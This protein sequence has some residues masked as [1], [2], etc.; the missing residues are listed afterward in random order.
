MLASHRPL[1]PRFDLAQLS[2]SPLAHHHP[3]GRSS[4]DRDRDDH[5][6]SSSNTRARAGS[7][8][9]GAGAAP[10]GGWKKELALRRFGRRRRHQRDLRFADRKPCQLYG[11]EPSEYLR[12]LLCLLPSWNVQRVLEMSPLRWRETTGREDVRA[13]LASNVYR[14]V[15]LGELEPGRGTSS[16]TQSPVPA[17]RATH[18]CSRAGDCTLRQIR[19]RPARGTRVVGGVPLFRSRGG[20]RSGRR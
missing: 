6:T 14:R 5:T 19:R 3:G 8:L 16:S 17:P 20:R 18:R 15:A 10:R 7:P 4:R 1:V 9:V 13:A 11:I 12:D 2:P